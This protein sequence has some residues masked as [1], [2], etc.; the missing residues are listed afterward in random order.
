MKSK[1]MYKV[2]NFVFLFFFILFSASVSLAE[3][4]KA[5]HPGKKLF[6]RKTCIAC[7]GKNGIKAIL[8][9]PNLA[10]QGKAYLLQQMNDIASGARQGSLD[11]SGN[12]RSAGMKGVMH[13]ASAEERETIADWLSGMPPAAIK[14]PKE[15]IPEDNLEKGKQLYLQ[16]GCI[17]CHGPEGKKPIAD[18]FP[19]IAGQKREYIVVQM[20]DIKEKLRTNGTSA[21]MV[22][23][24]ANASKEDIGYLADYLS[25]IER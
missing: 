5:K 18:I 15:P 10:G 8:E 1:S 13:L 3:E 25:Q 19:Y 7:H 17:A 22:P 9:Y 24:I 11:G 23:I 20:N 14:A 12:P 4:K 2:I 21:T 16:L 6:L